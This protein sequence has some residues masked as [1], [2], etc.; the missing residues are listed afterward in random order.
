[1]P[2]HRYNWVIDTGQKELLEALA[3]RTGYS[4]SEIL[5]RLLDHCLRPKVVDQML[6]RMSGQCLRHA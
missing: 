4:E 1:M 2:L 3:E 6:P 5:R